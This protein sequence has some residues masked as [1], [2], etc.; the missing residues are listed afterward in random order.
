MAKGQPVSIRLGEETALLVSEE[1]RRSGR[2]R[3]AVVEELADEAAKARLFPG[4]AFRGRP[5]RAWVIGTGVDVW[6]LIEL[7]RAYGGDVG[8]LR[9]NHPR[10]TDRAARIAAS[11]AKRFPDE[12]QERIAANSRTPTELR[13]LYPFLE[14]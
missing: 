6:E 8:K 10:V 3:S 11:Y 7:L 9:K 12:I 13:E 2:S 4:V 14:F 1:S 5:R